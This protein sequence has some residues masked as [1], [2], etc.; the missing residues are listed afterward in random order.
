MKF[1]DHLI[2]ETC[3]EDRSVLE[4][5]VSPPSECPGCGGK[6]LRVRGKHGM[7]NQCE[8]WPKC[9]LRGTDRGE[10]A[11]SETRSMRVRAHRV[12]DKLWKSLDGKVPDARRQA[13]KWLSRELGSDEGVHFGTSEKD[14]LRRA[15]AIVKDATPETI[16]IDIAAHADGKSQRTAAYAAI[17]DL[18]AEAKA[19]GVS[20]AKRRVYRWI[21]KRLGI[22]MTGLGKL[23]NDQL[24]DVLEA[25]LALADLDARHELEALGSSRR[26]RDVN[27]T[28]ASAPA[29]GI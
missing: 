8:N 2:K 18:V 9:D 10:M 15:I 20:D 22:R 5:Y 27:L 6:V 16:A 11:D 28:L 17:D 19:A 14:V 1:F 7:M 26:R 12:F 13:Y 29:R 3:F 21:F 23:T 4:L 25:C 24:S